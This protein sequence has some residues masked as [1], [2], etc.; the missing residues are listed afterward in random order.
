MAHSSDSGVYSKTQDFTRLLSETDIYLPPQPIFPLSWLRWNQKGIPPAHIS[1][2]GMSGGQI[3]N[4]T[5]ASFI[6]VLKKTK[7]LFFMLII[8]EIKK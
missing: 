2:S 5:A 6:A 3:G 1:V 8:I 7:Q 4:T